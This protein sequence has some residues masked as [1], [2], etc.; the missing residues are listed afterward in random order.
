MDIAAVS[1][2][3][4]VKVAGFAADHLDSAMQSAIATQVNA[5]EVK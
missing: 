3:A 5:A 1:R 4:A 2:D